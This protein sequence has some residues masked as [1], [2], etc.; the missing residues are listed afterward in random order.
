MCS[1][2]DFEGR[3]WASSYLF[4]SAWRRG[5]T[6]VTFELIADP[7]KHILVHNVHVSEPGSAAD[8][9]AR[10]LVNDVWT[11][12]L[13]RSKLLPPI[14]AGDFNGDPP[15]SFT[16]FVTAV[17]EY[18]DFI[19][20][21]RPSS[22]QPTV[23]PLTSRTAQVTETFPN[24]RVDHPHCGLLA[25]LVS[26]HCALFAQFLPT[27]PTRGG[28]TGDF[29]GDGRGDLALAGATGWASIPVALSNGDGSFKT[30]NVSAGDFPGF[31]SESA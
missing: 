15:A 1:L 8:A 2:I 29:N 6:A 13:P 21:G 22:Y 28:F 23:Y 3:H 11:R 5:P 27:T 4:G 19:L 18:V 16:D 14:V 10:A 30:S 20:I 24:R 26:D 9:A 17:T 31:A 25:T 12:W 7:G